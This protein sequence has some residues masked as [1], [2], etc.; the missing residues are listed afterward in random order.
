MFRLTFRCTLVV[1]IVLTTSIGSVNAAPNAPGDLDVSFGGFGTGGQVFT[2][3]LEGPTSGMV[4]QPD[5]QIV[6][7]GDTEFGGFV[8]RYLPNGTLDSTFG[9]DGTYTFFFSVLSQLH[10][11]DVALQ[12]DG[13][14]LVA[15]TFEAL[16][17]EFILIRVQSFGLLDYSFGENGYVTTT[18]SSGISE[19]NAVLIQPDGKIVVAGNVLVGG[20]ADFAVA[21]FTPDGTLDNTFGGDGRV[22][23][24]LGGWESGTSIARQADGK[25]VVAGSSEQG[26]I[27]GD[28]DFAIARLNSDGT[29]DS[30]FDGDGKVTSDLGEEDLGSAVFIQPDGKIVVVGDRNSDLVDGLAEEAIVARYH[31]DGSLD[32]SFAGDGVSQIGSLSGQIVDG[33]LQ[34]DGKILLLGYHTSPDGDTKMALY[35]LNPDGSTDSTLNGDGDALIDFGGRD[36][37]T[38]LALQP[39]G[40]IIA[41]GSRNSAFVALVR[42][43]PDGTFDTGG[44]QT[45]GFADPLFGLGSDEV[46]YGV[47]VQSD[48]KIVVAGEVINPNGTES[49]VGLARFLPNGQ[50]DTSFG[51]QGRVWF[52]FGKYDVAR[53]VALQP[54]GKIVIAGFSK[55]FGS[56][57]A[58]FLVARFNPD[59]TLDHTFALLGFNVVDFA[60]GD[61]YGHALALASDGKIVVAGKVW[62]GAR[63]VFG[64]ARLLDNGALDISFD[65]DGKAFIDFV[66]SNSANAVIVQPDRKIIVAGHV[67][68]DFAVARLR[69]DGLTDFTFG[70]GSQGLTLT[71]M[72]GVDEITA[73]VLTPGGWF[74]AGGYRDSG[75]NVDFAL[76]QYQPNGVLATCPGFPCSNWP[77]GKQFIDWGGSEIAYALDW[78][79]D[80]RLVAA[81]SAN[82][83]FAWVQLRTGNVSSPIKFTTDFVGTGD[84]ALGV[85]FVGSNK[86]ILAGYQEFNGD[87]NMALARFE[88]TINPNV[89]VFKVYLPSVIR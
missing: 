35:R 22:T 54:D 37:G 52:G 87:Q 76:T 58:N 77:T 57:A 63:Y 9:D 85:K 78:R 19:A 50:L 20:D 45:L 55:P 14:I 59:G 68:Q 24:G 13:K 71:D 82:G 66:Q 81:G 40:R 60:S 53:A 64:V 16:P 34:P 36:R 31:P 2:Y 84:Q 11:N 5:G 43:W 79:D 1:V 12:S 48:G 38:A 86:I 65:G 8:S 4:L 67:G 88:T 32:E 17:S 46:A 10:A 75:G 30:S 39:D 26:L 47:A 3:G 42:L 83:Q 56:V 73:L 28:F 89:P 25:L 51:D 33:A 29:L 69:E 80:G 49:D 18:F 70:P 7:I 74:Y 21:R 27:S 44:Q 15:G 62:N 41:Y 72:G 23:I 6:V 61:D